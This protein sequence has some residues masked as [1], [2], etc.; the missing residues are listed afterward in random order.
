M[1]NLPFGEIEVSCETISQRQKS[2]M[3]ADLQ[4]ESCHFI[5]VSKGGGR[6][7]ID[8]TVRGFGPSTA[9][10]VPPLTHHS[11]E[12]TQGTQGWAIVV[13]QRNGEGFPPQPILSSV[14]A[15]SDQSQLSYLFD[16]IHREIRSERVLSAKAIE[17]HIGLLSV[18][19]QRHQSNLVRNALPADSARR[20]LMRNFILL[21]NK[22]TRENVSVSDY[23]QALRVS[24]THL[25]RV[26][27]QTTG[28]PASKLIQ[29][30]MISLA[31]QDL[32]GS[33]LRVSQIAANLGFE[34]SAYFTRLFTSKTGD[35][36]TKFR[37]R[38]RQ[39]PGQSNIAAHK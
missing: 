29:D 3:A 14:T 37:A 36:P 27:R 12:F 13:Q 33:K 34:N 25:T 21:L 28:K 2:P 15:M 5:W 32:T 17:C 30:R 18:W 31:S 9:I 10:F 16:A 35:S 26:C 7:T 38:S 24:T 22:R 23:A 19:F 11:F 6:A 1:G 8:G 20:R 39:L 4:T